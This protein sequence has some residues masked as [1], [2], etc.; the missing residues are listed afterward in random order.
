MMG[1]RLSTMTQ[2]QEALALSG[3][4]GVGSISFGHRHG[5]AHGHRLSLINLIRPA[6]FTALECGRWGGEM[7]QSQPVPVPV[8]VLE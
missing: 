3:D 5:H 8:P 1:A 4:D 7:E 6:P 2:N